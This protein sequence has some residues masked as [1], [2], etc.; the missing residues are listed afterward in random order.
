MIGHSA[1]MCDATV[2]LV[3]GTGFLLF[4]QPS[5][6]LFIECEYVALY[7]PISPQDLFWT[8]N[9]L[10]WKRGAFL[11]KINTARSCVLDLC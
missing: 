10:G 4:C 2:V 1:V 6:C 8:G 3:V 7:F 11:Q 9:C 5:E